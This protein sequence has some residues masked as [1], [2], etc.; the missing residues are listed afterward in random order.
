MYFFINKIIIMSLICLCLKCSKVKTFK[1]FQAT[2]EQMRVAKLSQMN[3]DSHEDEI[4]MVYPYYIFIV[5]L[6]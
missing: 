1:M 3:K 6:R 5:F 2:E 4:R